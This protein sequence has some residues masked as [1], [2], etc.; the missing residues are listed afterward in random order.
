MGLSSKVCLCGTDNNDSWAG[1]ARS[2]GAGGHEEAS[3]DWQENK[4]SFYGSEGTPCV[5]LQFAEGEYFGP[6]IIEFY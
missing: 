3:I 6:R 1:R 4:V 2:R 5:R